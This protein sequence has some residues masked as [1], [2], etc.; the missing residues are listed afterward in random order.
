MGIRTIIK[1]SEIKHLMRINHKTIKSMAMEMGITQIRV[2][3]VRENGVRGKYLCMD[4][5]EALNN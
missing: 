3:E 4:W 5:S 1:G 2:R